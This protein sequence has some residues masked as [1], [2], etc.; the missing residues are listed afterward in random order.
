MLAITRKQK[1]TRRKTE[2]DWKEKFTNTP[3]MKK[4]V[5]A[6][7]RPPPSFPC[8]NSFYFIKGVQ[9]REVVHMGRKAKPIHLQI[10]EGNKTD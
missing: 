10:L 5:M 3:I 4:Q 1:K 6:P 9:L 2:N 8:K 7:W